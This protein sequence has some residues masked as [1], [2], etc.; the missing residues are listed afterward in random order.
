MVKAKNQQPPDTRTPQIE[1]AVDTRTTKFFLPTWKL[2]RTVL[3]HRSAMF[4]SSRIGCHSIINRLDSCSFGQPEIYILRSLPRTFSL[5]IFSKKK[6][7][8]GDAPII[9]NPIRLNWVN[10][11][12]LRPVS[13]LLTPSHPTSYDGGIS[14]LFDVYK[15]KE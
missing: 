8:K 7:L 11:K 13:I 15:N 9:N 2:G 4:V 1:A 12:L 3:L 14:N 10:W 6:V 5:T